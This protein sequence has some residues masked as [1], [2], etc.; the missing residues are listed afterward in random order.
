VA[1]ANSFAAVAF[2]DSKADDVEHRGWVR[3]VLKALEPHGAGSYVAEAD[4]ASSPN[5]V[6]ECFSAEA[7]NRLA[8]LKRRYDPDDLFF[9]YLTEPA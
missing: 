2:W 7:W 8:A 5:R 1:A 6:R 4:L 3:D 9:S